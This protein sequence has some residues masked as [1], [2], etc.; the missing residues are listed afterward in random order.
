MDDQ[1]DDEEK[2]PKERLGELMERIID[3]NDRAGK[4]ARDAMRMIIYALV[5]VVNENGGPEQ[6]KTLKTEL[7]KIARDLPPVGVMG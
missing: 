6:I 1:R 3:D 4:L 7:V 5:S 2:G